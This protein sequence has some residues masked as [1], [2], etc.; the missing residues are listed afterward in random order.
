VG[1]EQ[2]PEK[3]NKTGGGSHQFWLLTMTW[4]QV[5]KLAMLE[6]YFEEEAEE[7][8][9]QQ[10]EVSAEVAKTN[11]GQRNQPTALPSV[12]FSQSKKGHTVRRT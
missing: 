4:N 3:I 10:Q 7:E 8:E 2:W 1:L 9:Q 6:D 5:R 11:T 12:F